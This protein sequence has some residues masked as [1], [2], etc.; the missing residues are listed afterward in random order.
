MQW[1]KK[2]LLQFLFAQLDSVFVPENNMAHTNEINREIG[3]ML[4]F[5]DPMVSFTFF[6]CS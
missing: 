5:Y 2:L 3:I 4:E 1:R 6:Q